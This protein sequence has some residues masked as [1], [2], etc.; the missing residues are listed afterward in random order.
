MIAL[1]AEEKKVNVKS[2]LMQPMFTVERSVIRTRFHFGEDNGVIV[3][4]DAV[5]FA[6]NKQNK[7]QAHQS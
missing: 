3:G 4:E 1:R 2:F 7:S 5:R 6:K